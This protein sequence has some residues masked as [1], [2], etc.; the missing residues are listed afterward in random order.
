MHTVGKSLIMLLVCSTIHII[1]IP[2]AVTNFR[3]AP[4]LLRTQPWPTCLSIQ[5][6]QSKKEEKKLIAEKIKTRHL[7]RLGMW[8]R[9]SALA[10]QV[11]SS[12]FDSQYTE[13]KN[14]NKT[15]AFQNS[16]PITKIHKTTPILTR[17]YYLLSSTTF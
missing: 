16:C 14:S 3:V 17:T 12:R 1:Q 6:H 8:L 15:P 2:R 13:T 7:R 11:Q 10:W 5:T 4:Y 9:D